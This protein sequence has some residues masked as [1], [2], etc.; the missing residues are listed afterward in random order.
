M[1]ITFHTKGAKKIIMN[2]KMEKQCPNC[3]SQLEYKSG[4]SKT[5]NKNWAGN[6][7]SKINDQNCK[8]VEWL[9]VPKIQFV[10]QDQKLKVKEEPNWDLINSEKEASIEWFNAK[11][12]ASQII[13]AAINQGM[14]LDQSQVALKGWIDYI[15]SLK[16][17]K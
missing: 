2:T 11:N 6:F 3:G 15:Y 13:A 16:Q 9:D 10:S 8:Y 5:K 14:P 12:N 1:E 4:F 7:C 17:P